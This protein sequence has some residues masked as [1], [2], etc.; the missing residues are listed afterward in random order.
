MA[1]ALDLHAALDLDR[2]RLAHAA[3]V[4]A[5][6]VDEHHMLGA[7]LRVG[8]QLALE[9][10]VFL[11]RAA[12]RTRARKRTVD[13]RAA[14][15]AA[16]DLR[17]R[18]DEDHALALQVDLVRTRVDDAQRA[19]EVER[20]DRGRALEPLR[21]H[22]LERVARSDVLLGAE[23]DALELLAR[24]VRR[25]HRGPAREI[26]VDRA[27]LQLRAI[28]G[29]LRLERVEP[30]DERIERALGRRVLVDAGAHDRVHD[31]RHMVEDDHIA[32][33][34]E[35]KVGDA[36][37][38]ARRSGERQL[39]GLEV[40]D[41]VEAGEADEPAGE[42]KRQPQRRERGGRRRPVRRGELAQHGERIARLGGASRLPA[43]VDHR[44]LLR[45][46]RDLESR[47]RR[48]NRVAPDGAPVLDRFE[49]EARRRALVGQH[50]A[51]I[52]KHGRELVAHQAPR[53]DHKRPFAH[54]TVE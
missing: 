23:H 54:L 21:Q 31:L 51:A 14:V 29:E 26:E 2:A 35:V 17:A 36:A 41:A 8:E 37:V 27:M 44:H 33:E 16:E 46:R 45:A 6:E 24:H 52:G 32:V 5:A 20:V 28:R 10:G 47:A 34:A 13:H 1:V 30:V 42:R 22:H 9:R 40:A 53:E 50:E 25:R 49:E 7:F 48:K 11:E 15:H 38:V 39:R 12:A 3:E 4:V 19:V 18:R 43:M